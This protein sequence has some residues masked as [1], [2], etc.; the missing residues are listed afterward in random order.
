ML[1]DYGFV[2]EFGEDV[3]RICREMDAAGLP[4]P[5]FRQDGFMFLSTIRKISARNELDSTLSVAPTEKTTEK[6]LLHIQENPSITMVELADLLNLTSD[7]I[8]YHINHLRKEG[9]ISREGGR[10]NGHWRILK[11]I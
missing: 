10:K 9:I 8:Y 3:D 1:H 6:I 7:G 2:R 4:L 11:N 5:E